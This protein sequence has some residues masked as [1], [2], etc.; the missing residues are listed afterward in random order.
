MRP[1]IQIAVAL[2][3]MGCHAPEARKGPQLS[4]SGP[5]ERLQAFEQAAL[6]CGLTDI[7]RE[8]T[9]GV[10]TVSARAPANGMAEYQ[11]GIRWLSAHPETFAANPSGPVAPIIATPEH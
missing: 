10:A 11:C 9:N 7:T 1:S 6:A 3:L 8:T 4:V 2:F 5:P